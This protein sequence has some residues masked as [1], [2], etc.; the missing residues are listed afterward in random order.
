MSERRRYF[1]IDDTVGLNY[2]PLDAEQARHLE[3][4]L[5]TGQ[6]RSS[7]MVQ[8]FHGLEVQVGQ[9][10]EELRASAPQ[11]AAVVE[12]LNE[13]IN[14]LGRLMIDAR[15]KKQGGSRGVNL[16]ACGLAFDQD[17]PLEKGT[18]LEMQLTLFPSYTF[19]VLVGEVVDC[20][21]NEG[22]DFNIRIDFRYIGEEEQEALIHHMLQRQNEQLRGSRDEE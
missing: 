19:I 21:Q 13:K 2:K 8:L 5:R 10:L 1:R 16:S 17:Q 7:D 4:A 20:P 6:R 3:H 11:S 9:A 15:L 12:L 22:G 18:L 14:I